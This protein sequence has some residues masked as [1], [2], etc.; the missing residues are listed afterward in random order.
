MYKYKFTI[1]KNIQ[2]YFDNTEIEVTSEI[3]LRESE[4]VTTYNAKIATLK[5]ALIQAVYSLTDGY[6]LDELHT[7]RENNIIKNLE[8]IHVIPHMQI[9]V[10]ELHSEKVD[11]VS[12][13]V[14]SN[15]I[16][17]SLMKKG[18]WVG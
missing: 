13:I 8:K 5:S 15:K 11:Y 4:G 2:K 3:P 12:E 18:S 14:I 16:S 10:A 17:N 6:K 9:L 1:P 7:C